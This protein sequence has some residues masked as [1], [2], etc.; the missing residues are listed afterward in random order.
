MVGEVA[1]RNWTAES[2]LRHPVWRGFRGDKPASSVK[3]APASLPHPS[4]GD[5][6]GAYQTADGRWRVEAV[7][8]GRNQF[9]RVV[10]G[11]NIV[12]GLDIAMVER[13]LEQADVSMAALVPADVA[14]PRG[15]VEYGAT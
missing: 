11:E 4:Q 2:R 6:E 7:R 15:D 12:D 5:V 1:F 9:F 10:H 8:R 13:L 14:P 3:R